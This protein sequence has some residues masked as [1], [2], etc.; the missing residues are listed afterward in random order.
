MLMGT[1][2]NGRASFSWEVAELSGR[3]SAI[4]LVAACAF[5]VCLRKTSR[6]ADGEVSP[7]LHESTICASERRRMFSSEATGRAKASRKASSWAFRFFCLLR[8]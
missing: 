7:T 8:L 1:P 5:R 2:S 3:N 6:T 4:Q